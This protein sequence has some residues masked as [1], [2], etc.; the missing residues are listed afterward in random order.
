L[1]NPYA[2]ADSDDDSNDDN[3]DVPAAV[4]NW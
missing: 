1:G 3:N 2:A 4:S